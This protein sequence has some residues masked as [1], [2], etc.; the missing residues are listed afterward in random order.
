MGPG[1]SNPCECVLQ[2]MNDSN[3]FWYGIHFPSLFYDVCKDSISYEKGNS[4]KCVVSCRLS[5]I[6]ANTDF[7]THECI[8]YKSLNYYFTAF[9][10]YWDK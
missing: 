9:Y 7:C 4:H 6:H 1:R 8:S 5:F 3:M 2:R 10:K